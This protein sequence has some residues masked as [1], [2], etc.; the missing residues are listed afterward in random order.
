MNDI[1]KNILRSVQNNQKLLAILLDPDKIDLQ[2]ID[3][4]IEQIIKS[5]ATHLFIGGSIVSNQILNDLVLILKKNVTIPVV[6]FPG[7]SSQIS[8]FADG[9]LFLNLISGRNPKYLVEQQVSAVPFLN[10]T[11]LEVIPTAYL[12]IDGGSPSSVSRVSETL[13][14]CSANVD[15]IVQTAQAGVFMGNK[16]I[17]L[18]AGSGS[19]Q[20]I[21]AKIIAEVSKN[22]SI[23]LI[24]GGGIRSAQ[25]IAD[26]YGAG[27]NLVVIGTAFENDIS[28]FDTF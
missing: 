3:L 16:L 13:P 11:T 4:V 7:D 10:N 18:E 2:Q 21:P 14:M 28:F 5:P 27:A 12:L 19:K 1:L 23:P 8:A 24:V 20:P 6:L 9:I 22:I 15:F 25:Q 26:A 17:Y